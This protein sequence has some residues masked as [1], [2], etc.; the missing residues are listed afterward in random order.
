MW[1][2]LHSSGFLIKGFSS[3]KKYHEQLSHRV[4]DFTAAGPMYCYQL[5]RIC[6]TAI[7]YSILTNQHRKKNIHMMKI[8]TG[9]LSFQINCTSD[10]YTGLY[11]ITRVF[12]LWV[13]VV[14]NAAP[15]VLDH[16]AV[17]RLEN[18]C[19]GLDDEQRK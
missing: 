14:L 19:K 8:F 16:P 18:Y 17:T 1:K 13:Q 4:Q 5:P 10:N 7:S 6:H 2:T 15:N 9:L 11:A 12:L 3:L